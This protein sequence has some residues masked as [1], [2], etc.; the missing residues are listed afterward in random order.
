MP[1]A[2]FD[3]FG[4]GG[5]NPDSYETGLAPGQWSEMYNADIYNG[6]IYACGEEPVRFDDC[7]FQILYSYVYNTNDRAIYVASDGN[8]LAAY[9]GDEW[10]ILRQN[11]GGGIVTYDEFLGTLVINSLSGG[12]FFWRGLTGV[13]G[14]TTWEEGQGTTWTEAGAFAWDSQTDKVR[15]LTTWDQSGDTSWADAGIYQWN[16]TTEEVCP[17]LPGWPERA[18]CLQ[19][20]AFGNYLVALSVDYSPGIPNTVWNDPPF[21]AWADG[22]GTTW[23]DLVLASSTP[24]DFGKDKAP[25]LV[26]WSS[27]AAPGSVPSEWLPTTTNAAGDFLVQDTGGI[28]A[29]GR[30]L[31]DSLIIYKSD[32]IYRMFQT[33]DPSTVMAYERVV[34]RPSIES[35]YGVAEFGERHYCVSKA[36]IFIFDGQQAQQVDYDRVHGAVQSVST[37]RGFDRVQVVA[38]QQDAEIWFGFRNVGA[39]PLTTVLKYCLPY[40]AFTVH[41]YGD[42]LTSLASGQYTQDFATRT[43]R[44]PPVQTWADAALLEWVDPTLRGELVDRVFLAENNQVR[45]Y[46][47]LRG[48]RNGKSARPTSLV[49]YGIRLSDPSTKT[50]LRAL[51]PEMEAGE[52]VDFEIGIQHQPWRSYDGELPQIVWG[53]K[54]QFRPGTDNELPLVDVGTT[55]AIRI[56]SRTDSEADNQFWRLHALGFGFETLGQYG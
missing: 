35:P 10:R 17:P 1:Y 15:A 44:N 30:K 46:E 34:S 55:Y 23:D 9:V 53:P 20:V 49:R 7:P 43:W 32:S 6:D 48:G 40:D 27:A 25:Y 16:N 14:L 12:P 5:F 47:P 37:L 31:R 3:N 18:R 2:R 26:W 28:I 36:G 13:N 19:I 52:S 45:T 42:G 39:G 33:Y 56:S 29:G 24:V 4:R 38:N 8:T 22:S 21:D 54:R 11:L 51:Y 41:Q 50:M